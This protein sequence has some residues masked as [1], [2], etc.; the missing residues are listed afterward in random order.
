MPMLSPVRDGKTGTLSQVQACQRQVSELRASLSLLAERCGC[1]EDVHKGAIE[2]LRVFG[3]PKPGAT[4]EQLKKQSM[5]KVKALQS[6]HG[7]LMSKLQEELSLSC[8]RSEPTP[9]TEKLKTPAVL[10]GAAGVPSPDLAKPDTV[11][12]AGVAAPLT[13]ESENGHE[14]AD[15]SSVTVMPIDG[16]FHDIQ[17]KSAPD[18]LTAQGLP[19]ARS[20]PGAEPCLRV[21]G[22][23]LP[24]SDRVEEI[25][26]RAAEI[27]KGKRAS[28]ALSSAETPVT[29]RVPETDASRSPIS[30]VWARFHPSRG[31]D[32]GLLLPMAAPGEAPNTNASVS[33][34]EPTTFPSATAASCNGNLNNPF[35]YA[36]S[37]VFPN[38]PVPVAPLPPAPPAGFRS[39]YP[40]GVHM[41]GLPGHCPMPL[42]AFPL[43]GSCPPSPVPDLM[44]L[45]SLHASTL[46]SPWSSFPPQ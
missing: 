39:V 36:Q 12:G 13:L 7:E 46:P 44:G 31:G 15:V 30:D 24:P 1:L 22:P 10:K 19:M 29:P 35:G 41:P 9:M 18:R 32:S 23:P 43:G 27:E 21:R 8:E 16:R 28:A 2:R 4:L 11:N 6:R 17:A 3:S 38:G 33:I 34:Q 25:R 20:F 14:Q 42:P 26:R 45:S 5:A 37:R 40:P